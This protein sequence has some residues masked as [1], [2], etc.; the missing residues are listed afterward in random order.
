MKES[1]PCPC[2]FKLIHLLMLICRKL[3]RKYSLGTSLVLRKKDSSQVFKY[4][5]EILKD[6]ENAQGPNQE[7]NILNL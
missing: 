1:I 2:R 7:S 3:P 4:T 5:T 6:L